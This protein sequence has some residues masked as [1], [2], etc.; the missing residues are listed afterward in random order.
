MTRRCVEHCGVRILGLANAHLFNFNILHP[1]HMCLVF[2]LN[3]TSHDFNLQRQPEACNIFHLWHRGVRIDITVFCTLRCPANRG[4]FKVVCEVRLRGILYTAK[5]DTAVSC[6]PQIQS[7]NSFDF[8]HIELKPNTGTK[9][10][11]FF[12]DP[13]GLEKGRLKKSRDSLSLINCRNAAK[14]ATS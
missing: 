3:R 4:A 12:S 8:K 2:T 5:S 7:T 6:T 10:S 9:F 1:W 11:L 13:V 14:V